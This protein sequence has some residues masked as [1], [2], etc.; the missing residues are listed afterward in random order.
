[1]IVYFHVNGPD[2]FWRHYGLVA[3]SRLIPGSFIATPQTIVFTQFVVIE[4][5][6]NLNR[7]FL[8]NFSSVTCRFSCF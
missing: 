8:A 1:M 6:I 4:I 2:R 7:M 3:K 5:L